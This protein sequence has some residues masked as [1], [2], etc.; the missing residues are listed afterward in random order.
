MSFKL[1]MAIQVILPFYIVITLSGV[2]QCGRA[3]VFRSRA[4]YLKPLAGLLLYC[5]HTSLRWCR[6][7]FWGYAAKNLS[8]V[9]SRNA[10]QLSVIAK[11]N[12][13][14]PAFSCDTKH[15]VFSTDHNYSP[16]IPSLQAITVLFIQ[17]SLS[18]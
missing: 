4:I 1:V 12:S 2:R 8:S 16:F 11:H 15:A 5:I 3:A 6:C 18:I 14:C 17:Y 9:A 13:R 7:A 10:P